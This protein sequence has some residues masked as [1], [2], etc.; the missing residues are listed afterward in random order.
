MAAVGAGAARAEAAG[1]FTVKLA[2]AHSALTGFRTYYYRFIAQGV[3]SRTGRAGE[4]GLA[5][6]L[7]A[8]KSP[9]TPRDVSSNSRRE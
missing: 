9:M 6:S 8:P 2:I 1:D 5:V 4:Q 3:A 7:V